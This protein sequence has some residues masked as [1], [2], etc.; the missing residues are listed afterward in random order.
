MIKNIS[1]ISDEYNQIWATPFRL[2]SLNRK[3]LNKYNKKYLETK[4]RKSGHIL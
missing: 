3:I 2:L 4:S 1:N